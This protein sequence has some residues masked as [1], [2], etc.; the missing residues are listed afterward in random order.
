MIIILLGSFISIAYF[1]GI[2]APLVKVTAV[3]PRRDLPFGSLSILYNVAREFANL[4]RPLVK[5][6]SANFRSR[7]YICAARWHVGK[8]ADV[9]S[10]VSVVIA[11]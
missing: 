9:S 2:A 5:T 10:A 6:D 4:Q 1:P 11:M 3:D 8:G 7:P